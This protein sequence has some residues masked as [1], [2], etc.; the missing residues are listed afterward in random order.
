MPWNPKGKIKIKA[1]KEYKVGDDIEIEG[2]FTV[3]QGDLDKMAA[4][5][6]SRVQEKV[7]EQ[8]A[9]AKKAEDELE[10]AKKAALQTATPDEKAI[11]AQAEQSKKLQELADANKAMSE[12]LAAKELSEKVDKAI[13]A[14][15]LKIPETYRSKIQPKAD[16]TP[17]EIE[18]AIQATADQLKTDLE[19]LGVKQGETQGGGGGNG[20]GGGGG[21]GNRGN[22][23]APATKT[24]NVAG[25]AAL[26]KARANRPDL[27]K[28]VSGKNEEQLQAAALAW[29]AKGQLEPAKAKA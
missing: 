28:Y 1:T 16:A 26:A 21:F 27:L 6:V 19:T 24:D 23:G 12:K 4:E 8:E 10:K 3:D 25:A 22:G 7:V 15:G 20:N 18:A 2:E 17:A 9:R 5:R 11:A 29:D 14:K 13:A